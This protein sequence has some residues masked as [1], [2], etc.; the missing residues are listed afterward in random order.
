MKGNS[1]NDIKSIKAIVSVVQQS[2]K[3]IN[4]FARD[5]KTL[6]LLLFQLSYPECVR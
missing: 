5:E 1:S 6:V 2:C 4:L 3:T